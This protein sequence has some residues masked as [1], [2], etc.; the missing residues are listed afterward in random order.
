MAA[1]LCG[2]GSF[3]FVGG[4]GTCY[5]LFRASIKGGELWL[6]VVRTEA[7]HNEV[8]SVCEGTP[9]MVQTAQASQRPRGKRGGEE[10]KAPGAGARQGHLD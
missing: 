2:K 1:V 7:E 4:V 8:R 3:A 6:L 10:D 9:W 5:W